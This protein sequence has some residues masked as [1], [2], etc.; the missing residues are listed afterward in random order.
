MIDRRLAIPREPRFFIAPRCASCSTPSASASCRSPPI[1][2]PVPLAALVDAKMLSRTCRTAFATPRCRSR[3]RRG[4]AGWRRSMRPHARIR[5]ARSRHLSGEQQDALLRR[6]ERGELSG[7]ALGDMPARDVLRST[8]SC[9]TSS[10]PITRTRRPGARSALA[11]RRARAAMSAWGSIGAT[12]GKRRRP[13]PARRST[14]R[15]ENQRVG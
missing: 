6:M 10:P 4:G 3:A 5:H 1:A 15:R 7:G 9:S 11:A 14:A 2:P 8:V 12:R 13:S